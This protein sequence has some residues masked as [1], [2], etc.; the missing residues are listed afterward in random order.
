MYKNLLKCMLAMLAAMSLTAYA[1]NDRLI[2]TDEVK[3]ARAQAALKKDEVCNKCHDESENAP[4]LSLYQ[5]KHGVR[6]DART[7]ICQSCQY[8]RRWP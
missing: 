3:V 7:P 2:K 4:I 5:T 1:Q 8:C 6:G